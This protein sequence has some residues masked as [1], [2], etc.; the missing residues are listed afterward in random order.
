MTPYE[1]MLK[2]AEEYGLEWEVVFS[3]NQGISMGMSEEEACGYA[4]DEWDL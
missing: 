1:T 3:Y 4:L 2:I